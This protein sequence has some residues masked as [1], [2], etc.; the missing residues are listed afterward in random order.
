[1]WRKPALLSVFLIIVALGVVI[2]PSASGRS[3]SAFSFSLE[4]S[5]LTQCWF[6]LVGFN[7]T[8]GEKFVIAWN[9][10]NFPPVSMNF[11]IAPQAWLGMPWNCLDGPMA[12]YFNDGGIGS[13]TWTAS[14]GGSYAI[15]LVNYSL[16]NVSGVV[17]VMAVNA[18]VFASP[19]GYGVVLPF[20]CRSPDPI[21]CYEPPSP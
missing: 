3:P 10:T 13:A 18:T 21:F 5:S 17:S 8:E 20:R 2:V 14:A 9:E 15:I 7:A 6:Y 1:M 12:L 11:Y 4:G 19:I 16:S